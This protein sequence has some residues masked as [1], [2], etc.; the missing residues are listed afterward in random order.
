MEEE[1]KSLEKTEKS[2][3]SDAPAPVVRPKTS[4]VEFTRP[5]EGAKSSKLVTKS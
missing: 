5:K 3:S 1:T 4:K 2:E